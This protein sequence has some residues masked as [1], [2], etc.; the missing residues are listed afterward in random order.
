M[1][2]RPSRLKLIRSNE[3]LFVWIRLNGQRLFYACLRE[4]AISR[5]FKAPK[6]LKVFAWLDQKRAIHLL[7]RLLWPIGS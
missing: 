6:S 4:E 3:E 2:R 7:L 1:S 5:G